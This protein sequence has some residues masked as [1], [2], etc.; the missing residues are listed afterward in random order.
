MGHTPTASGLMNRRQRMA[1]PGGQDL[2]DHK[3]AYSKTHCPGMACVLA[4]VLARRC[5]VAVGGFVVRSSHHTA[6]SLRAR[7]SAAPPRWT[8]V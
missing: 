2:A 1:I 8:E 3:L 4:L 5:H 7:M 6:A